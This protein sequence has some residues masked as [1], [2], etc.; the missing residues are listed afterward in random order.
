[1]TLS[2]ITVNLNNVAGLQQTI[3]SVL[4]QSSLQDVEYIIIDGG[5]TDGSIDIIK[6]NEAGISEWISEKDK[7]IY[8]AMNKGLA[9]ATGNYLMF[10]NSG[11]TLYSKD[12]LERILPSLDGTDIVYGSFVLVYPD[13]KKIEERNNKEISLLSF[14]DR[15]RHL[16]HQSVFMSR[17]SIEKAGGKFDES[18][19]IVA[20]WKMFSVALFKHDA[21]HKYINEYVSF[22]EATGVS[23]RPESAGRVNEEKKKVL[24]ND[25]PLVYKDFVRVAAIGCSFSEIFNSG[26]IRLI[27]KLRRRMTALFK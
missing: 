15:E 17:A 9:K 19:K 13:G 24:E 10:L 18:L 14:L 21:T 26:Y 23:L 12:T 22:F 5:S 6:S 3:D 25:F 7:G 20:D 1:M 27:L 11:D 16:C 8:N 4:T 2:I